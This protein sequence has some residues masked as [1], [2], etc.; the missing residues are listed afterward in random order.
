MHSK[1]YL[2]DD[3]F[4]DVE[5]DTVDYNSKNNGNDIE[6]V[7][8][9]PRMFTCLDWYILAGNIITLIF[10]IVVVSLSV[11][12]QHITLAESRNMLITEIQSNVRDNTHEFIDKPIE[13]MDTYKYFIDTM[14][15]TNKLDVRT[16]EQIAAPMFYI[17]PRFIGLYQTFPDK[18][19]IE[20]VVDE[21][22]AIY[23]T[24]EYQY[25]NGSCTCRE[26]NRAISESIL[27]GDW[28]GCAE[29]CVFNP[30][31]TNW[32]KKGND[33]IEYIH[34]RWLDPEC[35][36]HH[37]HIPSL[38]I[39]SYVFR[40]NWIEDEKYSIFCLKMYLYELETML[41]SITSNE[42]DVYI[43][44][45]DGAIIAS[46]VST[47]EPVYCQELNPISINIK[48][49]HHEITSSLLHRII[50]DDIDSYKVNRDDYT[51]SVDKVILD[52]K[53]SEWLTVIVTHGNEILDLTH[54]NGVVK[55]GTACIVLLVIVVVLLPVIR[56][57]QYYQSQQDVLYGTLIDDLK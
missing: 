43:V 8:E 4:E 21:D 50:N 24:K 47:L 13:L 46:S 25:A 28:I 34:G 55:A 44:N 20:F 10:A 32:Y 51:L 38:A 1:E 23:T 7:L 11:T 29:D 3:G 52:H 12:N 22:D 18:F 39:I 6:M 15:Y 16:F 56:C 40:I 37:I 14:Y 57:R 54:Y 49:I 17:E 53:T 35:K 26:R 45:I 30:F 2:Q 42:N 41:R 5:L 9:K 27:D 36:A 48:T 33:S 19:T 31:E